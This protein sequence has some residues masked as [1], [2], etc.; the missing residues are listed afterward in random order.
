MPRKY[1]LVNKKKKYIKRKK[2][3]SLLSQ[4]PP[5]PMR[6]SIGL[7][8]RKKISFRYCTEINIAST[9]GVLSN[10]NF[11][12]NGLYDPDLSGTGHQPLAFDQWMTLYNYYT[13]IGANITVQAYNGNTSS[14]GLLGVSSMDSTGFSGTNSATGRAESPGNTTTVL[15]PLGASGYSGVVRQRLA[16]LKFLT[17]KLGDDDIEGTSAANPSLQCSFGVWYQ[18]LNSQSTTAT[19]FVTLD[20]IAILSDP[21]EISQ[22]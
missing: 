6:H 10:H 17:K 8:N 3:T 21:K 2:Q 4:S 7:P 9:A 5:R 16:P 12:A 20:Y 14:V 18:G 13:V 22:S 11:S 15:M 1:I 19:C